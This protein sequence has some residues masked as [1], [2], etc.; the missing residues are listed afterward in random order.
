M[1]KMLQALDTKNKSPMAPAQR[2]CFNNTMA[3]QQMY[4]VDEQHQQ[5][6]RE[7]YSPHCSYSEWKVLDG[8]FRCLAVQR[9]LLVKPTFVVI[10]Y[11]QFHVQVTMLLGHCLPK[12]TL[13]SLPEHLTSARQEQEHFLQEMH[14]ESATDV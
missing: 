9:T 1:E 12:S 7:G 13:H 8:L 4:C 3:K 10:I 11:E 6:V 2:T 14:I 5:H